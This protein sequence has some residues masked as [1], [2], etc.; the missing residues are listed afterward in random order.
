M[1][2]FP[3]FLAV[4]AGGAAGA[5]ARYYFSAWLM[6]QSAGPFPLGTFAVNVLGCLLIGFLYPLGD[7]LSPEGKALLTSGFLGAFTTFSTFSL[8]IWTLWAGKQ[9]LTGCG[10]LAASLVCGILSVLLGIRLG[11]LFLLR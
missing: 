7:S 11:N 1:L 8:E 9:P 6:S 2:H 3:V 10:Y 4:A 5:L